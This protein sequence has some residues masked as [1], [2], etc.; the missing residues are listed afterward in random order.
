MLEHSP[1][2]LHGHDKLGGGLFFEK[3]GGLDVATL[4]K[5]FTDN[6]VAN[7]KNTITRIMRALIVFLALAHCESGLDERRLH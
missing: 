7:I 4:D 3:I 2:A 1:R 6:E 5:T